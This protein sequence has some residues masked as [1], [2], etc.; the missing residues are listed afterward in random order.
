M[1]QPCD[2]DA[3]AWDDTA[4]ESIDFI[5]IPRSCDFRVQSSNF[6]HEKTR[7]RID[8]AGFLFGCG[9]K[10]CSSTYLGGVKKARLK[11]VADPLSRPLLLG[12]ATLSPPP[13]SEHRYDPKRG[14][15]PR[16]PSE[17][18]ITR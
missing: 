11:L 17:Q 10:I 15:T 12:C 18:E 13:F 5:V 6:A 14:F 2:M 8:V 3:P 1:C 16:R 7:Q 4:R 9:G